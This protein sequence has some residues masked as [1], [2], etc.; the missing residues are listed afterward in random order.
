MDDTK[1]TTISWILGL[2]AAAGIVVYFTT[3][4][5]HHQIA[6]HHAH[7]NAGWRV[8]EGTIADPGKTD[9]S[10]SPPLTPA[11]IYFQDYYGRPQTASLYVEGYP[12][13]AGGGVEVDVNR[14]GSI[15]AP[16]TDEY[17]PRSS[18][19]GWK[20]P[21]AVSN[22]LMLFAMGGALAGDFVIGVLLFLA[23]TELVP[24]SWRLPKFRG[25]LGT[26]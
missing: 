17:D 21:R 10:Q 22:T 24:S 12:N 23:L 14:N 26:R 15:F 20:G 2:I 3:T 11:T 18:S 19:S 8:H 5:W 4:F 6:D 13:A 1:A 16:R 7:P 9:F 25:R